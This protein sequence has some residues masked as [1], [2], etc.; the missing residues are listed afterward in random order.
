MER[1]TT[2]TNVVVSM[3][4]TKTGDVA[5]ITMNR[6]ERRNALSLDHMHDLM[7]AFGMVADT[8][9][10]GVVVAGSGPAFS[11]G[12]DFAR[13]GRE[14][15][16]LHIGRVG[17]SRDQPMGR[18]VEYAGGKLYLLEESSGTV[19]LIDASPDGWKEHGRFTLD[20]QT[21]Q[22]AKDGRIW[23]HPVISNGKLYL[24]DQELIFCFDIKG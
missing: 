12:H 8:D 7:T 22:R 17:A 11:A 24:R 6:P 10:V 21:T 1:E 18:G 13:V 4:E 20:P 9:A 19:V 15:R 5:T 3:S 2:L 16:P 23:T 14:R